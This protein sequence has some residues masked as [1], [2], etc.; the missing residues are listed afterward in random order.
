MTDQPLKT[1]SEIADYIK[2][3]KEQVKTG[4]GNDS[5]LAGPMDLE[6]STTLEKSAGGGFFISVLQ[7]GAEVKSEEIHKIKIPIKFDSEADKVEEEA[8]KVK[9]ETEKARSEYELALAIK[10]KKVLEKGPWIA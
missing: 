4:L 5:S 2:S 1:G 10:N 6:I 8:R 7:A 3:F 9:A